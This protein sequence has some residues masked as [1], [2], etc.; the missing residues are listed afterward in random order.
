M[1]RIQMLGLCRFSYLGGAGFQIEHDTIEQRRA[2]LYE[3]A[4]LARRWFWF[5]NVA[6]PGLIAQ[7]DPDF[8]LV[9]MTGPDLPEPYLGMLRDLAAT[10]P[11]IELELVEPMEAHLDACMAAIAPHV[12]PSADIVGHFRHDDDDAVSVDYIAAARADFP[13][14]Q[15]AFARSRRAS[16]DY[17]RGLVLHADDKGLRIEARMIHNA[18]AGLTI[19]LGP[20]LPRS[21][22]HYAHWKL[23]LSMPGLVLGSQ[24]RFVRV[25]HGDNDSGAVGAS[26]PWRIGT[27]EAEAMLADRFRLDLPALRQGM[28]EL[29]RQPEASEP[30]AD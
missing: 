2:F 13:L 15:L 1:T 30:P 11:Q 23:A 16:I 22:V 20:E 26:Y 29:P 12:E 18:V 21:A 24:P 6:L 28:R 5:E 4:R 9:V 3:P 10:V 17:P 25:L 8:T 14:V 27:A 7:T 19:Y